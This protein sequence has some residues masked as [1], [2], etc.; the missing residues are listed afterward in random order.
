MST[1]SEAAWSDF[2]TGGGAGP[3]SGCLPKGLAR[4][5]A[6]QR[7]VW[8][9]IA[10]PL[11]KGG[12]VLDLA[13]GDGAVLGKIRS[14]RTD[15]KLTGVDS[16][17]RLPPGPKGAVLQAGIAMERLPFPDRSFD[18]V[19]SQ[20]GYEYG[21]RAAIAREVARVLAP[22]GRLAF[23]VHHADGPILAHNLARR[24]GLGWA[25]VDSG[26]LAQAKAL[27][28]AR[29]LAPLPTPPRFR[30]APAEARRLYPGQSVAEEFVT[31]V[32]QS[33]ELGRAHPT[34]AQLEALDELEARGRN[35]MARIDALAGAAC[36]QADIEAIE[37]VLQAAGLTLE[38]RRELRETGGSVPFAWLL[39][40]RRR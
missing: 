22:A 33:L 5:D 17:A 32:L 35:E 1:R 37:Q 4:I 40:G 18:L 38:P 8:A 19:T 25:V 16:A 15:L 34:L 30:Q 31:A 6:V 39:T 29:A 28:R 14:S 11:R 36:T 23:I 7:Q 20:F 21:D 24:A 2:W 12:R 10:A 27:V 3:E 26:L 9:E 13:T